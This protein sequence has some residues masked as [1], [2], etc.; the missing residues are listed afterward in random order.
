[1]MFVYRNMNRSPN[2][3][4]GNLVE[5]QLRSTSGSSE[6]LQIIGNHFIHHCKQHEIASFVVSDLVFHYS[7]YYKKILS[8]Q[9]EMNDKHGDTSQYLHDPRLIIITPAWGVIFV[10][11]VSDT[12]QLEE[13]M[14]TTKLMLD[15][16]SIF[17]WR[18]F[19]DIFK[20]KA[21][22]FTG[23]LAIPSVKLEDRSKDL[24]CKKCSDFTIYRHHLE[25][26]EN[27]SGWIRKHMKQKSSLKSN[28]FV[29][30]VTRLNALYVLFETPQQNLD[31]DPEDDD[32]HRLHNVEEKVVKHVAKVLMTP[33]Q[34]EIL[35]STIRHRCSKLL[36][37]PELL[38][39]INAFTKWSKSITKQ[40]KNC[41]MLNRL[42]NNV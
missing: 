15:K 3:S 42:I 27:F 34:Y 36:F 35:T 2:Y 41:T 18:L 20:E 12:G 17:F 39:A 37:T 21:V 14:K 6:T 4:L 9:C 40:K 32:E 30:V 11:V 8:K 38:M 29:D 22:N 19:Q 31:S 33:Q 10:R 7:S 23:L 28:I 16:D 25:S 1:M 26:T 13:N 24:L 5:K